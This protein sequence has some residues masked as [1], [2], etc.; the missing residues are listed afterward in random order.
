MKIK[1]VAKKIIS[2][3]QREVKTPVYIPVL[4]GKL[5]KNKTILIT[6]GAG[7]IGYAIAARCLE[8]GASVIL[9][10][11][12]YD[13]LVK[14]IENLTKNKYLE[15]QFVVPL[16]LN[17]K[18]IATIRQTITKAI[19]TYSIE[20]IDVLV[21]NAGISLGQ[22]VGKTAE[23]DYDEVLDTNL[24]G[25]YFMSQEFSNYL[26]EHNIQGN[27]LNITSVSGIRPAITPYMLSK[28]GITGMTEG[29]AKKLIKY[30]IVVNGI[31]PGP[32]ATEMLAADG[33]NLHY[34]K[35]P[36]MRYADPVEIANLAVFL[37][38]DMGRM[39]VGDTV[40][41]TGGCGNLTVDD[42]PY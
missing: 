29:L 41:I 37:I 26:V 2:K 4:S 16:V 13:K 1:S 25:T 30:G 17:V 8:N 40:Y 32:T 10:G 39:I 15:D 20:K 33:E 6:G 36:A 42:I 34:E 19:D 21:N 11:R 28:W 24:K 38:S 27:I 3:L 12:S 35:S 5:L 22:A 9:A 23:A 31:A 7:G 14:A 18:N